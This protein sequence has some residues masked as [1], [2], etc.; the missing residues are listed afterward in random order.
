MN[1]KVIILALCIVHSTSVLA[2]ENDEASF[3][4]KGLAYSSMEPNGDGSTVIFNPKIR[5]TGKWYHFNGTG[6]GYDFNGNSFRGICKLFG[7]NR[8]LQHNN[9]GINF[10]WVAVV[11]STGK[12]RRVRGINSK[13]VGGFTVRPRIVGWI[14]CE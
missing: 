8:F 13:K 9:Q 5:Y 1:I 10:A 3:S 11:S 4:K 7:F 14:T 2:A 12:V 6:N